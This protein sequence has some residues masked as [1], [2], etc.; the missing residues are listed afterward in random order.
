[1]EMTSSAAHDD[2]NHEKGP[3]CEKP[4]P[5]LAVDFT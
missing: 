3:G 2:L 5:I 1:M 4:G